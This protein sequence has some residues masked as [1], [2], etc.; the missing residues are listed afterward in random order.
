[1]LVCLSE[2]SM[3]CGTVQATSVHERDPNNEG[4]NPTVLELAVTRNRMIRTQFK[5]VEPTDR[6]VSLY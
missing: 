6:D 4:S 2:L 1:V 5:A 3:H